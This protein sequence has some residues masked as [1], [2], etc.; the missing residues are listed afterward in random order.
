MPQKKKSYKNSSK[1]IIQN[2]NIT[3]NFKSN[4]DV[5]KFSSIKTPVNKSSNH[6]E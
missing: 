1:Q 3:K 4:K 6:S 5:Q 2:S